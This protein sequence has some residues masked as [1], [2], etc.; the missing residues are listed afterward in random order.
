AG[1]SV[2]VPGDV[3]EVEV[4]APDAPGAPSAGRLATT[5]TQG[6]HAFD[7]SL[8]SLP[9]VDDHQR[10][11][12]WGS[13]EAAG[14]PPLGLDPELRDKLQRVPAAGLSA[15]LRKRGLNNV[16]VDGVAPLRA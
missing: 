16:M 4:D 11:E 2:I 14:L 10:T 15:Q 12:A 3:V 1:S 7:P 9:A 6:E 13:R 8:G 5:V